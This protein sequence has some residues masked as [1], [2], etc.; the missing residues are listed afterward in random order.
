MAMYDTFRI[1]GHMDS[2]AL[3]IVD[4]HGLLDPEHLE[5]VIYAANEIEGIQ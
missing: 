3:G 2:W 4:R 5:R 1:F